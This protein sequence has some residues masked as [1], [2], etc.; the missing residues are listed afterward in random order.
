M[1]TPWDLACSR[2]IHCVAVTVHCNIQPGTVSVYR[3]YR[4]LRSGRRNPDRSTP[5]N[6]KQFVNTIDAKLIKKKKFSIQS[7]KTVLYPLLDIFPFNFNSVIGNVFQF[8]FLLSFCPPW[9]V[10][11]L[12]VVQGFK[13]TPPSHVPL[14]FDIP[15]TISSL[16]AFPSL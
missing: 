16:D 6:K 9:V 14:V 2:W 13:R 5:E 10:S 12:T 8:C 11:H 3:V 1:P 4:R 7:S 15:L